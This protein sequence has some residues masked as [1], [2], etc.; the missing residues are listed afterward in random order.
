M[1]NSCGEALL[2]R[3]GDHII[4]LPSRSRVAIA[5]FAVALLIAAAPAAAQISDETL[6]V[7]MPQGF[8]VGSNAA[9]NNMLM[10]EWVPVGQSVEN[11]TEMV[12]VQVFKG[13]NFDPGRFLAGMGQRWL[14]ACPGSK[15]DVI[16]SGQANGYPVSM[17]ML[18]CALNPQTAKPENTLFRAIKGNDSFYL[19]QKAFRSNPSDAQ[20]AETAKYLGTVN[21]CDTRTPEHPCPAL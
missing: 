9:R 17:L 16:H 11:W 15:P 21:V 10:Q 6:L 3:G 2:H 7:A 13:Q 18:H 8:I 20:V 14:A 19:V 5:G 1:Q 12:T 4:A